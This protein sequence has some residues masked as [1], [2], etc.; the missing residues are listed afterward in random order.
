[1]ENEELL[2]RLKAFALMLKFGHDL[3][4][5]KTFSDAA[6]LAVNN[7]CSLLN[8]KSA[9]LL[10]MV[11]GKAS[12]IA[13]YG[14]SEINPHSRLAVAQ[15]RFTE[16]LKLDF[17]PLTIAAPDLP[18]E[19]ATSDT[20]YCCLKLR[21][22][23]N[24]ESTEL[25]FIWLLAYEKELPSY[26]LNTFKLLGASAAEALYY[27][28]FCKSSLWQVKKR[29]KKRWVWGAVLLLLLGAMFI[30]VPESA[31]AEFTLIAPE[32]TAA[33]AWFDGAIA[34]CQ[35]QNGSKVRKGELV[36]QYDTDQLLYRLASARSALQE[37]EEE[38]ALEQQNAFTEEERLGKVKLLEARRETLQI[39]VKEAQ[40]YLDHAKIKA[41]SDGIL[42]LAD[43]RAEQ[44]AGKA[45]RTGDKLFEVLGG[46]GMIAEIQLDER[47][48]S[49]LSQKF[50]AALFLHIA[51]ET[52]I[53]TEI[54]EVSPYPELTEH[55]TFCYRLRVQLP[56]TFGSL[57]YGMRG[58]ARISGG[59]HFLGYRLFKTLVLYF[60]GL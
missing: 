10:E 28:R 54:L 20:L 32:I 17:E 22:P 48:A 19:L 53:P 9:T 41:P 4:G 58:V 42:S 59:K 26:V 43:G 33:Y 38:L 27:Q 25:N 16:S 1:M 24:L 11:E 7:S 29:L 5:A 45:V 2:S 35:I 21:P 55:N 23:A 6:A 30:R 46:R 15:C 34:S 37:L 56:D 49:V 8:F 39:A 50:S 3:F 31:T 44:L 60:R 18:T 47:A 57:R 14:L 13:Q 52:A 36:A 12:V 51:P 40:W